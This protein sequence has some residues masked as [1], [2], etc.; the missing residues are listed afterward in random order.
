MEKSEK[1]KH[2]EAVAN[3]FT[4]WAIRDVRPFVLNQK[5]METPSGVSVTVEGDSYTIQELLEAH[6]Q[7]LNPNVNFTPQYFEDEPSHSDTDMEKARQLDPVEVQELAEQAKQAAD[8]SRHQLEMFKQ[9]KADEERDRTA[10][11]RSQKY[12]AK[13]DPEDDLRNDTEDDTDDSGQYKKASKKEWQK[14][15]P[16]G[17]R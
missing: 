17:E 3:A 10:I 1:S 14:G 6:I 4:Q 16:K 8:I 15:S 9:K 5:D 7:G 11:T 2:G 13:E 12:K